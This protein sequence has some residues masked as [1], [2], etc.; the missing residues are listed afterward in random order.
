[1]PLLP[2][3]LELP[4]APDPIETP[5]SLFHHEAQP[6]ILTAPLRVLSTSIK[7]LVFGTPIAKPTGRNRIRH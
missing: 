1:M 5:V 3:F 7:K 4:V 2:A 6:L